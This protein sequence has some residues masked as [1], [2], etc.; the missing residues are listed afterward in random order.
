[1]K[2]EL[3]TLG[4]FAWTVETLK[5]TYSGS[6]YKEDCLGLF[7]VLAIKEGELL[8]VQVTSKTQVAAH[9]RKY[10][11]SEK[12]VQGQPIIRNLE[13]F[14]QHGGKAEIWGFYQPDGPGGRWAHD[15]VPVTMEVIEAVIARRRSR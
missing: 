6:L 13:E 11:D 9:L 12:K 2:A 4:Y 15:V 3:A 1:M 10:A 8:G 5:A 14:L 7:D